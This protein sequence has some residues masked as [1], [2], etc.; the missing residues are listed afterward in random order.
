MFISSSRWLKIGGV[1]CYIQKVVWT[2]KLT[3]A[4][5]LQSDD[6]GIGLTSSSLSRSQ[7]I[8]DADISPA[9]YC[10]PDNKTQRPSVIYQQE[11]INK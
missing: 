8:I 9:A 10:K 7:S 4:E 11:T 5:M 6:E 2:V 3:N 1:T